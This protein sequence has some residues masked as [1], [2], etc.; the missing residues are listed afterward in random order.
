MNVV[1]VTCYSDMLQWDRASSRGL[2]SSRGGS[3]GGS[4]HGGSWFRKAWKVAEIGDS[5]ALVPVTASFCWAGTFASNLH[6]ATFKQSHIGTDSVESFG[7]TQIAKS[8]VVFYHEITLVL[9]TMG[10]IVVYLGWCRRWW[11]SVRP[12]TW[13]L[14]LRMFGSCQ[15]PVSRSVHRF[16]CSFCTWPAF[17][18]LG[19]LHR[20][21]SRRTFLFCRQV[22]QVLNTFITQSVCRWMPTGL[23]TLVW[24]GLCKL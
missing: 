13:G 16:S 23:S 2:G 20:D 7:T 19:L 14:G 3:R 15:V 24:L 22:R 10:W 5:F 4:S 11:S 18:L 8:T 6:T 1:T 9:I 17:G 21:I 12:L